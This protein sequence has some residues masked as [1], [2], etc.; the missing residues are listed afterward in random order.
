MA[1]S[2]TSDD[3]FLASLRR[4]NAASPGSAT[5]EERSGA[6]AGAS[7]SRMVLNKPPV[8][9]SKLTGEQLYERDQLREEQ[10][11]VAQSEESNSDRP[12]DGSLQ[13]IT[14]GKIVT[15]P[16]Y[17][18]RIRLSEPHVE[19]L[20][21]TFRATGQGDPIKVRYVNGIYELLR[22]HHR[23]EA[24]KRLGWPSIKAVVCILSDRDALRDSMLGNSSRLDET[25]YERALNFQRYLDEGF[26]KNQGELGEAFGCTQGRVSQIMTMLD[27]P[28]AILDLLDGYPSLITYRGCKV[29]KDLLKD[30]PE[31]ESIIVESVQRLIDKKDESSIK[32]WVEQ[33]V[34]LKASKAPG[35]TVEPH[36]IPNGTGI[37]RF[38]TKIKRRQ[39]IVDLK[40]NLDD[41]ADIERRVQD[42]L[43]AIPEPSREAE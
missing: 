9:E 24:A 25:D 42:L 21:K 32:Q 7:T 35:N 20:C 23:L 11:Q 12:A 36:V 18:T 16:R 37:V 6:T 30:H 3:D 5:A 1:K 28:K 14:I 22:G 43:K 26:A 13:D 38:Q 27:L 41:P 19:D 33:M 31:H 10:Q 2:T 29:I 40:D 8:V 17:Q 15:N 34:H 4:Q 39:I